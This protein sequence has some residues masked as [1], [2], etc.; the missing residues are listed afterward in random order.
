MNGDDPVLTPKRIP[1]GSMQRRTLLL[2]AAVAVPERPA[3]AALDDLLDAC[4]LAWSARR[5]THG[6]ARR[7]PDRPARDARGLRMELRW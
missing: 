3:G 7:V 4:A 6:T 2:G 1:L 5:I